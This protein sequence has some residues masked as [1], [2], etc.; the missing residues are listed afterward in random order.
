MARV[1][2]PKGQDAFD[3][4]RRVFW[5][6]HMKLNPWYGIDAHRSLG[7]VNR[8][9]K[10]LYQRSVVRRNELNGCQAETISDV[11]QIP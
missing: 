7:S 1:I 10:T 2:L 9:R 6:D 4:K 5:E 11:N 3:A 8:L